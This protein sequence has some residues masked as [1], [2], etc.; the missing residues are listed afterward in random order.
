MKRARELQAETLVQIESRAETCT[1]AFDPHPDATKS[2]PGDT[3]PSI[4]T[5]GV[6]LSVYNLPSIAG[7]TVALLA[8][9][10]LLHGS[11]KS[12]TSTRAIPSNLSGYG[13]AKLVRDP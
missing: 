6:N 9:T 1:A 3:D 11:D 7:A 12:V 13:R 10:N 8:L 5:S 2:N 4:K